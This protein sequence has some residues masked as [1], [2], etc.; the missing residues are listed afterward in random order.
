MRVREEAVM[1][2]KQKTPAGGDRQEAE[3][4]FF[5]TL[6]LEG[7]KTRETLKTQVSAGKA[8]TLRKLFGF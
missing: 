2:K 8:R 4:K 6:E 3:E 5:A 7:E 1:K